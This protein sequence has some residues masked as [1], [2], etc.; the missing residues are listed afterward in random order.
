MNL[1]F[2][3]I[4]GAEPAWAIA[5]LHGILGQGSNLQTLARR[6]V[7][8][9][10]TWTAWLVDLRGHGNSPKGTPGASLEAAARDIVALAATNALP[11]AAIA[12]HSFGGKVALEVARLEEIPSLNDVVVIDSMPGAREPLRGADSALGIIAT[13]EILPDTFSS[14]TEFVTHLEKSG[15]SRQVAQWLAGSVERNGNRL[16]FGLDLNE[17][18]TLLLDYFVRDLWPVVENPPR[19]TR[20]QLVI[21]DRSDSYSPADRERALRIAASNPK[22][23][24]DVLPAGHWVHVD[25]LEG[26][27]RVMNVG[28]RSFLT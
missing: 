15:L 14:I 7:G 27:L 26:L 21:G 28:P 6:F 11:L 19:E 2:E 16:R 17:I 4:E 24:V 23:T 10:P 5:F 9:H 13:L 1:A 8:Q 18:R 3:R 22:V 12:G 20:L 25:N